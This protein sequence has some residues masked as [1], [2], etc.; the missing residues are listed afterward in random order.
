LAQQVEDPY[1]SQLKEWAKRSLPKKPRLSSLRKKK[2]KTKKKKKKGRPAPRYDPFQELPFP[3]HF[4]FIF[5]QGILQSF[6]PNWKKWKPRNKGGKSLK[7]KLALQAEIEEFRALL[8]GY[9][10]YLDKSLASILGYLDN[11]RTIDRFANFL[12]TYNQESFDFYQAMDSTSREGQSLFYFDVMIRAWIQ[13]CFEGQQKRQKELRKKSMPQLRKILFKSFISYRRYR[14]LREA[15][16]LSLVMMPRHNFPENLER[17]DPKNPGKQYFTREECLM[18]LR[19]EGFKIK[20]FLVKLKNSLPK[21]S[22]P[23]FAHEN[24]QIEAVNA[25]YEKAKGEIAEKQMNTDQFLKEAKRTLDQ[26]F[27]KVAHKV[28]E[29]LR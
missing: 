23:L 4:R 14:G 28:A 9:P 29:A 15:I 10:P 18:L 11:D 6:Q 19:L 20:P 7:A 2:L 17:Y 16:A 3:Y 22:H 24:R 12:E 5:G 27:A 8:R 26:S 25:A 21:L 1:L 13:Y